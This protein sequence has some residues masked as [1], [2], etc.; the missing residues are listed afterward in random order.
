MT[1]FYYTP[2][3]SFCVFQEKRALERKL[4]ELEEEIKVCWHSVMFSVYFATFLLLSVTFCRFI[5]LE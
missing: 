3:I 1:V 5:T 4:S 2:I